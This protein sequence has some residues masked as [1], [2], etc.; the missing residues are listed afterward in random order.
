M[1][2]AVAYRG[3]L[4]TV[5]RTDPRIY[6]LYEAPQIYGPALKELIHEQFG[7]GIMSAITSS[8]TSGARTTTGRACHHLRREVSALQL[9]Q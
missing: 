8:W 5:I 3:G 2:V 6:R 1:L 4:L 7:E 9:A